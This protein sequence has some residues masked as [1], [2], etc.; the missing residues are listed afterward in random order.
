MKQFY[1]W[2]MNHFVKKIPL[3]CPVVLLVDGHGSHIDYYVSK[4]C[5]VNTILFRLPPHTSHVIQP[6]D[7]GFFGAFKHNFS[8]ETA[9]FTVEHPG[10][11]ITKCQ[12]V[13]IFMKA[14]ESSCKME[15]VKSSFWATGIW[16]T[17]RLQV[18]HDLFNPSKA[19]RDSNWS[20]ISQNLPINFEVES[21][22]TVKT[23]I[24]TKVTMLI[25]FLKI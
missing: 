3:L 14:Y 8:K 16:P 21:T 9:K 10:V 19:Y 18:D 12:F 15:T 7:T 2:I 17:D 25:V 11:L 23:R 1:G 4:F 24:Q 6:T 22:S 13:Y 20:N 5:L